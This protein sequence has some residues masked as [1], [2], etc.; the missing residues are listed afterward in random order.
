MKCEVHHVSAKVTLGDCSL[1]YTNV[2][3]EGFENVLDAEFATLV[4]INVFGRW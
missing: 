3:C 1:A 4:D 2:C